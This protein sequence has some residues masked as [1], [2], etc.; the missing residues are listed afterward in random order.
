MKNIPQ[1]LCSLLGGLL[2]SACVWA[3]GASGYPNKPVRIIVP[4]AA[5]GNVDIVARA[6]AQE[7]SKTWG[8][9]V[10]VENRPSAASIVGT[11]LVAKSA[12]D[13]YTLLAHSSTFFFRA[14]DFGQCG[15][16]PGE[17]FHAHHPDL[18]SPHVLGGRTQRARAH[19]GR[20]G[21]AGQSQAG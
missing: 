1:Q 12:P 7:L 3:Q 6:V 20:T 14:L 17:R 5:G 8:Q 19:G 11:Q 4:V 10:V 16:R 2:V 15:V 21:G 18:Q 13:G 9:S